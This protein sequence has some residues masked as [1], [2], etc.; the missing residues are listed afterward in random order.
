MRKKAQFSAFAAF[1]VLV[2]LAATGCGRDSGDEAKVHGRLEGVLTVNPAVDSTR[3]Y[4]GFE[5]LVIDNTSGDVDTLGM[6]VTDSAGAFALD[7]RAPYRGVFPLIVSRNDVMLTLS[8][9]VVADGDSGFVRAEFP[10]RGPG[11][12]VRGSAENGAWMAYR[13]AKDQH[14]KVL[15]DVMKNRDYDQELIAR[16]I[17]QTSNMM[18]SLRKTYPNTFGSALAA[19]EAVVMLDGW[20]DALLVARARE[21]PPDHP[22]L[23]EVVRA[24]RRAEA[25]LAGQEAALALVRAFQAKAPDEETWVALQSEIVLAH[26]DSLEQREALEAAQTLAARAPDSR[27][28]HWSERAIYE[29]ENLMPGM[30]APGFAATDVEG[31]TV[32]LDSLR[33]RVVLLEYYAPKNPIFQRELGLRNQLFRAL[34]PFP[35]TVLSISVDPDTLVN[36]AFLEGRDLPGVHI[37][38]EGGLE[39]PLARLYNVNLLPTRFLINQSG[40]IVSK[41]VGSAMTPLQIQIA[42]LLNLRRTARASAS[43][44]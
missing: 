27:W 6:A 21:L 38:A 22:N 19:T 31:R 43:T 10:L 39:G 32:R 35:F 26:I 24:A 8:E 3:D 42:D 7:V 5:V 9:L 15:V 11:L 4:S 40:R 25:R 14:N 20:D 1:I 12:I 28:A 29:L 41:Y 2:L 44:R 16:V 17:R 30:P 33:G 37:F 34:E 18:W 13:N 36:E 23:V